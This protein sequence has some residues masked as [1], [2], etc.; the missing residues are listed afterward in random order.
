MSGCRQ[1]NAL[2]IIRGLFFVAVAAL[3]VGPNMA[4]AYT[5]KAVSDPLW[6]RIWAD[7]F[8]GSHVDTDN[9]LVNNHAEDFG[10]A[11]Y[12]VASSSIRTFSGVTFYQ[13]RATDVPAHDGLTGQL[14][15]YSS[16]AANSHWSG[17]PFSFTYGQVVARMKLPLPSTGQ[18]SWPALWMVRADQNSQ[19]FDEID[20]LENIGDSANHYTLHYGSSNNQDG[21]G[22]VKPLLDPRDRWCRYIMQWYPDHVSWYLDE[23]DGRGPVLQFQTHASSQSSIPSHSMFLKLDEELGG[24]AGDP[25]GISNWPM[26]FDVDWIHV[27]QYADPNQPPPSPTSP[28][29]QPGDTVATVSWTAAP[30][31]TSYNVYRSTTAGSEGASPRASGLTST[32]YVDSSVTIG[33]KYYYTVAAVNGSGASL[34][35]V[36]TSCT[37]GLPPTPKSVN[38]VAEDGAVTLSWAASTGANVYNIY[39]GTASGAE[40]GNSYASTSATSFHDTG[41]TNGVTYFYTVGSQNAAG[42]SPWSVEVAATPGF[43]DSPPPAPSGLTATASNS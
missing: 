2:W 4:V 39:R 3:S 43:T 31:S 12:A 26:D 18:G 35:S 41:L 22:A 9:W 1:A 15:D 27:D 13:M 11:T 10:V 23:E 16:G 30:A 33:V 5:D 42:Y 37:V 7:E 32:G 38:A 40:N 36:E 14:Y 8:N 19:S 24:W 20:I 6:T 34:Q 29:A 17:A 28:S 21:S 25:S